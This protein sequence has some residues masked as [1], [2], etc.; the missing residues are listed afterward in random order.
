VL[1]LLGDYEPLSLTGLGELLVCESGTNPS[2]LV[3]RAVDLGLMSRTTPDAGD[4]RQVVLRLTAE[5]RT[6]EL[7]V[8]QIEEA[9][10]TE[11]DAV[12]TDAEL[13]TV[14]AVLERVVA[15]SPAGEAIAGLPGGRNATRGA[16]TACARSAP[17]DFA[18]RARRAR[19][20]CWPM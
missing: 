5:G 10:Y 19:R 11:L 12:G 14:I 15:G 17:S 7:A 2:R 20:R 3:D 1:R 13:A 16:V 4:R 8:R 6:R 18:D 9:M